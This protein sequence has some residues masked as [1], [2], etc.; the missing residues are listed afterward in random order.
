MTAFP[1][2]LSAVTQPVVVLFDIDGTLINSGGAGGGALLAALQSTFG[3]KDPSPV[4]LHGRTD[5]GIVT[6]L[7]ESHGIDASATNFEQLCQTY[8][9]LLPSVLEQRNGEVLPGVTT[10]LEQFRAIELC[11]LG[12]LTGNMPTSAQ[13]KLE[14]FALW[15]FFAGGT[16][17]DQ[18]AV[19]PQ[20]AEPAKA[21]AR[22]LAGRE[23]LNEC[24]IVIGDTPLDIELA[25]VM[26]ARSIAVCTGGYSADE[27]SAS[28]ADW[29]VD[30]L[31][32]TEE[33][34]QWC[35][36]AEQRI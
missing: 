33:I 6:E 20:L 11:E 10:L 2:D 4:R 7:L 29:V 18:A 32:A 31:S 17:G 15:D 25:I 35:L 28:G 27:L 23:I 24:V 8:Y 14:H 1:M 3:I 36:A 12:L 9:K 19:R 26:Q 21:L 5:L 13:M 22:R 16:F 34:V 30:D